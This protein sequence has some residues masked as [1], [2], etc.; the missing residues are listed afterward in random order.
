MCECTGRDK[1]VNHGSG[2]CV[3]GPRQRIPPLKI[4]SACSN[5]NNMQNRCNYKHAPRSPRNAEHGQKRYKYIHMVGNRFH[6]MNLKPVGYRTSSFLKPVCCPAESVCNTRGPA[7]ND[8]YDGSRFV[9]LAMSFNS[10]II[11]TAFASC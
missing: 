11:D 7:L 10:S 6:P 5:L 9:C 4:I 2:I 8:I 3:S 1:D